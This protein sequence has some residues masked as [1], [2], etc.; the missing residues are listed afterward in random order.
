MKNKNLLFSIFI[1]LFN[2]NAFA[3]CQA[4]FTWMQTTNNVISFTDASTG[5]T[6][7]PV[8]FWDFGDGNYA[9]TQNPVHTFSIPG[10]YV[11]C[12]ML[13]DSN[14]IS[15][16]TSSFCDSVTVTGTVI[17]NLSLSATITMASC[18]TCADGAAY[19]FVSGGMAP[20]TYTWSTVPVQTQ[21][22]AT[23]LAPGTYVCCVTDANSC[24]ACD[25]ITITTSTCQAGFT[26]SQTTNNVISFTNTS[27]GT[28]A[29]TSY[30]WDFGDFNY[31]YT[32][33]PVHTYNMPGIYYVCLQ[34]SDSNF[35]G[36]CASTF[37]DS[38]IV[39][40]VNCNNLSLTVAA[41]N[42]SCPTCNDGSATTV[43]TGG[44]PP[45]SY[46][47]SNA[48][49]T[50]SIS[51]LLPG[52]YSC[53]VTDALG[54]T[55]CAG[56]MVDSNVVCNAYFTLSPAAIPHT[57]TAVNLSTGTPPI[58]YLWSWGD[59]TYDNT[60]YPTH[61]YATA[62]FYTI[63]LTITDTTLCTSTYCDSFN[64]ARLQTTN[65]MVTINVV[66]PSVSGI[67]DMNSSAEALF[68]YPNPAGNQLTIGNWQPATE[69]IEILDVIG[70]R[71]YFAQPETSN[72]KIQTLDISQLS[73]GIYFVKARGETGERVTRFIK[74]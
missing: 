62:G 40:G 66:P 44:T 36:S 35:I 68:V 57:Y 21:A 24:S 67:P 15:S 11:V 72:L 1:L 52:Y 50:Q 31:D 56:A 32:Q 22:Y 37:C 38:I 6:G 16:C 71:V 41:T 55:S 33:N 73:L 64:V 48:A 3:Q 69:S 70:Q 59:N 63:C 74:L 60:P 20:Y 4:N 12:L 45:Y 53:C 17:C 58:S 18:S 7:T 13:A 42:A 9:Y 65:T 43:V 23:G 29:M 28:T 30:I 54:C 19:V 49:T 39:T 34:I 47:W 5:I 8:Y 25:T 27:T 2:A 26:W 61:T 51:N 46:Q 10:T 14:M